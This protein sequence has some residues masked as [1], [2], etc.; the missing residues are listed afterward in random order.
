L[1]PWAHEPSG[2]VESTLADLEALTRCIM[3]GDPVECR[4]RARGCTESAADTADPDLKKEIHRLGRL[5][6]RPSSPS[7]SDVV[8]TM[9][10]PPKA[11]H[12]IGVAPAILGGENR[13]EG[14]HL[15]VEVLPRSQS[16][17]QR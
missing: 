3:P 9:V 1:P 7:K 14:F 5:S 16:T 12:P 13:E 17:L 11:D 2:C 8:P 6:Q 15:L 10:N 4:M